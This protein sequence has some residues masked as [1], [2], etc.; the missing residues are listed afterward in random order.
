MNTPRLLRTSLLLSILAIALQPL[1]ASAQ[2]PAGAAKPHASQPEKRDGQSDFDWEIGTWTTR[3]KRRLRPLTGS[4]DWV[5][6]EGTTVVR[7]VWDGRANLVE[8]DVRGPAGRI[9]GLSLRLYN[10]ESRQWSLNFASSAGGTLTPPSIGGF[11]D[12][13]GEFYA[14][15]TLDGRAIFVRFVISDMTPDSCRF[16]QAFSDDGGKTWEVNWIA[17]DRRVKGRSDKTQ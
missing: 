5:E 14:Q 15:E 6:Y 3:L 1:Q 2:Q 10:P 16:E 4:N 17:T 7:K 8:L 9:E 13:R 12:G 11:K